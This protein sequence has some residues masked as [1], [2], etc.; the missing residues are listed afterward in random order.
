MPEQLEIK[1]FG[2]LAIRRDE[3]GLDQRLPHKARALLVYLACT[4]REMP[5]LAAATLLWDEGTDGRQLHRLRVLLTSLRRELQPYLTITRETLAF[6][7][8]SRHRLDTAELAR[9]LGAVRPG[10]L[11]AAGLEQVSGLLALYRGDFLE[12]FYLRGSRDFDE[13]QVV[14]REHWRLQVVGLL[15]RLVGAALALGEYE[16]GLALALDWLALDPLSEAAYRQTMRLY[17]CLGQPDSARQQYRLCQQRLTAE[18]GLPLSPETMALYEALKANRLYPAPEA[19]RPVSLRLPSGPEVAVPASAATI[20]VGRER[21]LDTLAAALESARRGKT[22][23]RF[24][25][26]GAGRG[27]S[28]L[29]QEFERRAQLADPDLLVVCGHGH[30]QA[31][32][33]TPYLPWR[34]ALAMLG[35]DNTGGCQ[36]TCHIPDWWAGRLRAAMAITIPALVAHAPALVHD[37]LPGQV[38]RQWAAASGPDAG[39]RLER[40]QPAVTA[41][42]GLTLSRQDICVQVT[43]WL[44]AVAAR[45]PLVLILE[46]LHWA[47]PASCNLLFYL[48]RHLSGSPILLLGTYRPEALVR[49]AGRERHPLVG[50]VDEFRRQYGHIR[51]DLGRLSEAENRRFVAAYLDS[52]PNRLDERFREALFGHTQGH[53]LF[54]VELV[55]AMQARGEL[56]PDEA[57]CWTAAE[58]VDWQTLPAR[59]EGVIEARL[60]RLDQPL[61]DMLR[62]ASVQGERFT[63]EVVARVQGRDGLAVVRQLS[64][65]LDRQQRLVSARD[66]ELVA[67]RRLAHYRFCH[68]LF[69][70]YVYDSL[71]EPERIYLHEAVG[72]ALE[73]LYGGQAEPIAGRLAH[74]FREARRADKAAAYLLA[75][76]RQALRLGASTEAAAHLTGGLDLLA[77]G[78]AGPERTRQEL[79][80][81]LTLDQAGG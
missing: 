53:P 9:G 33:G 73:E 62:I 26:G 8:A 54:T 43:A 78:H 75:A 41:A 72:T 34:E 12:G 80:L 14:E 74:H 21:Q 32:R 50:L 36:A 39:S 3:T 63:A 17:T 16:R 2:G 35:G 51:L 64:H 76:G 1:T 27:K 37:F 45:R 65:E 18:A 79:A 59:V 70:Q 81:Q 52:R 6:N 23:I 49:R 57:G 71:D 11:T 13:W 24:V 77:G 60:H 61:Q 4:G 47:D 38:W 15:A 44:K 48:S 68:H 42:A 25:V 31:G 40:L 30:D 22:R 19:D 20:F 28:M 69:Q 56:R 67:G 5:R 29:V 58:P 46:D 66:S 10:S 7:R 55:Q